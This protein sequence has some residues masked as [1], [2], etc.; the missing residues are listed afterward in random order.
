MSD[1]SAPVG[2]PSNSLV[3][4]LGNLDGKVDSILLQLPQFVSRMDKTEGDVR[5]L[6]VWQGYTK[7]GFAV[8][9]FIV[10]AWEVIRYVY[11]IP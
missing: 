6:Q 2:R 9:L 5:A 1:L 10:T 3:L 11:H 4:L 8:I 7:G